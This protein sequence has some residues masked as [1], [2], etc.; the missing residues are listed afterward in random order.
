MGVAREDLVGL[1]SGPRW[2]PA[3][4]G[5]AGSG[6][7]GVGGPSFGTCGGQGGAAASLGRPRATEDVGSGDHG[8]QRSGPSGSSRMGVPRPAASVRLQRICGAAGSRS[9]TAG[10]TAPSS[11]D[12]VGAGHRCSH[13][14]LPLVRWPGSAVFA[15]GSGSPG[16]GDGA[17][18]GGLARKALRS[19]GAGFTELEVTSWVISPAF[20]T[21]HGGLVLPSARPLW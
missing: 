19:G 2:L 8:L 13:D 1:A 7:H 4:D 5:S 3:S 10:S 20:P 17:L 11:W 14:R 15:S 12:P 16:A 6:G 21:Q 18:G 9:G